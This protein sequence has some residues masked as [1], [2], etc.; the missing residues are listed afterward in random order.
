MAE[1]ELYMAPGVI[2]KREPTEKDLRQWLT[3]TEG[4]TQGLM[5]SH[6]EPVRLTDY[7]VQLM[8]DTSKFRAVEKSRGVGFSFACAAE[9]LAKA[10]LQKDFTAVMVSMNLHEAIEKIR[11][12]NLLYES[13]PLKFRKRK[14]V[15]NRTSIEL[16]DSSTRFRSRILSHPCKDP[17]GRHNASVY[18]DEFAHYGAKQQ[19]IYVASVPVVS[20][21][22]GQLTIG[23]TPLRVGDLFHGIMRQESRKYPMF[24][25]QSVPW[26]ACPD[27][28]TDVTRSRIEA[29][30]METAARVAA[31]GKPTLQD[32]AQT[33]EESDFQQEYE[34][35]YN[36]ESQTFFPYDLIFSCCVDD[37]ETAK[38]IDDLFTR[39]TG[40]LFMG[41]DVGRTRNASELVVLERRGKRLAYAMGKSFER[42]SFQEQEA[43]LRE[44]LRASPRV[45]RL[46]VDRH[47]IGMNLAENLHTEF[48]SRVEGL[49]LIGQVK[50]SLAVG[51]KIA[52]ENEAV[53]IPRDRELTAQVHSIK[54]SA[55]DAGYAR[56]DTEKNEKHHSDKFWSLALAIHAAGEQ[57]KRRPRV[58][59]VR[60]SVV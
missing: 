32:I 20:R 53:A 38:T 23:S 10:H 55:T 5:D 25:R 39:T 17:R 40:D 41:F 33:M 46:C 36:D 34:L 57:G 37:M 26:W 15:D 22:D 28:C 14:V 50:E 27:F 18:L 11:Y 24:T 35:A 51:M 1:K 60:A 44:I 9:A 47:G 3:T 43:F 52:F 42:S 30:S 45:Q 21:G 31:F 16:E 2:G 29:P 6:D 4:F 49:A 58:S 8:R 56:F 7:Q 54:K 13:M 19:A 59:K 48:R 12:A